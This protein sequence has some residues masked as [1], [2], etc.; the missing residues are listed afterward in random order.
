[1]KKHTVEDICPECNGEGW[2]SG[3]EAGHG[4]DGTEEDC[5]RTCPIQIQI[6]V[7][8]EMCGGTGRIIFEEVDKI[9]K[10]NKLI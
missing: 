8:C 1:M 6:Q 4:C 10:I 9:I 7:G 3:S 5:Q 2:Y